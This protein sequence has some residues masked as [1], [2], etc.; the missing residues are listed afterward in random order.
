MAEKT[1]LP[2]VW[3]DLRRALEEALPALRPDLDAAAHA[4][5]SE[6]VNKVYNEPER[7]ADDQ[8]HGRAVCA[9]CNELPSGHAGFVLAK[10][11]DD[12]APRFEWCTSERP[13]RGVALCRGCLFATLHLR[14]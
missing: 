3:G 13:D 7:R 5:V 8:R 6:S 4:R 12:G 14:D 1:V 9:V 11:G 2:W 10:K